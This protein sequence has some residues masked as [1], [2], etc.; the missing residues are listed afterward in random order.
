MA[1]KKSWIW[2]IS[3]GFVI[4][5]A[6]IW[7]Y[8]QIPEWR[9]Q[10]TIYI[11]MT[12]FIFSFGTWRLERSLFNAKFLKAIPKLFISAVI[13]FSIL[14]IA[15]LFIGGKA[16]PSIT[17]ALASV[18]V[19][20]IVVQALIVA[21]DES[22]VFQ[23]WAVDELR[24]YKLKKQTV[25]LVAG[26]MFALFHVAM[27]GGVWL[28]L[29]PYVALGILFLFVRDRFSPETLTAV[30]GVHF[31]YNL[32]ILAFGEHLKEIISQAILPLI[33]LI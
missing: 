4:L 18:P 27:A 30:I 25:Y 13:T 20:L 10:I 33:H 26:I 8:T 14:Y 29:L 11:L 16:I 3:L 5:L 1:V 9:P 22:F 32:F 6:Q 31:G 17:L 24:R 7:V 19:Y 28:L 23:G 15:S 21:T 2:N 12:A